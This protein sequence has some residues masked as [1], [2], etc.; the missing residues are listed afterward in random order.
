[1][2]NLNLLIFALINR[3]FDAIRFVVIHSVTHAHAA[4]EIA[5]P[6]V[7][8]TEIFAD[9]KVKMVGEEEEGVERDGRGTE[10][11]LVALVHDCFGVQSFDPREW[12]RVGEA[13]VVGEEEDK[14][15]VVGVILKKRERLFGLVADVVI[16]SG[17]EIA[18][19]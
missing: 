1:M 6:R 4:Q 14:V 10:R 15:L 3:A 8:T 12:G 11:G 9:D 16:I 18:F 17:L 13:E 19:E 2:L 7:I 5:D